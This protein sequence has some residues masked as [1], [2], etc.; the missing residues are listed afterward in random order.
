MDVLVVRP[1]K[2]FQGR[3][4]YD[5]STFPYAILID[6][7]D[8]C[9]GEPGTTTD[10]R[11]VEAKRN[12]EDGQTELLSAIK[13]SLLNNDLPFR[14]FIASR[15]ELSIRTALGPTGSLHGLA[16]QI[17]LSD[18]YDATEDMRRYLWRRFQD[19]GLRIGQPNWFTEGSIETL[20][21]AGSGQFVYVA[22]VFKYVSEL[23]ASPVHTLKTVLN[24]TPGQATRPFEA[25]D[26]LYTN[27]L[28]NAKEAYEAVDA[29]RGRDFLL[30]I[31]MFH[32]GER[33]LLYDSEILAS[34]LRSLVYLEED[35]LGTMQ[36][37]VYHKSFS[38]FMNEEIRADDLFVSRPHVY[39]H[40]AK[41]CMQ[42]IIKSPELHSL[43]DEWED[44]SVSK[45]RLITAITHLDHLG[46]A[47]AIDDEFVDFTHKGGWQKVD[48]VLS[49]PLGFDIISNNN[50]NYARNWMRN[51][52]STAVDLKKRRPEAAAIMS[53]YLEKWKHFFNE[54]CPEKTLHFDT[55]RTG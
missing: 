24:W 53:K 2:G 12:A 19:I 44:M 15:P 51:L 30:F 11:R 27:I 33:R 28:S 46:L 34:D 38:D 6:G 13:D 18:Q 29:H 54:S 45:Q 42:R 52:G 7:I 4:E 5:I 36:L 9:Q 26:M 41:C 23:R 49:K 47:V 40:L 37:T 35:E 16:Y 3:K 55:D 14:I 31:R 8:E 43:L 48:M 39:T 25:L 50:W 21:Q 1:F 22:T 10:L 32:I 17:H 20:V